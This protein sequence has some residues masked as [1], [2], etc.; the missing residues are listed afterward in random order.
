[1]PLPL[2]NL[3]DRTWEDLV[4]EGRALIPGWSPVWTNYN[5][6]DPGITLIELF[7]YLSEMLMY[8]LNRISDANRLE[9]LRLINGPGWELKD[10]DDLRA[11]EQGTLRAYRQIARAVT[12]GDFEELAVAVNNTLD[13]SS[14]ERIARVSCVAR[15]NLPQDWEGA[16]PADSSADPSSADMSLV[17]MGQ[18]PGDPS[19]SLLERVRV[20][21]EPA[22]LLTVRLHVTGPRFVRVSVRLALRAQSR[23]QAEIVKK[24]AVDALHSFFDPLR[25][26]QDGKGW[27]FGRDVYISEVYQ[28]LL[29]RVQGVEQVSPIIDRAHGLTIP[30]L[31]VDAADQKR[32]LHNGLQEVEAV[33]LGPGELVQVGDIDIA[34]VLG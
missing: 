31:S 15:R 4:Q 2:P 20:A 27:P 8:Q 18:T 3:D 32:L 33:D 22:R 21:L 23:G 12:P 19:P 25:G 16:T 14:N 6:S 24:D 26:G 7:A 13:P 28:V 5:P 17:V 1:M 29:A 9:F 11:A 30:E 10:G 34:V